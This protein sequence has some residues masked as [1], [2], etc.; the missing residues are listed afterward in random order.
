MGKALLEVWP[1][2]T[3]IAGAAFA[4]LG[5][6]GV[7][8]WRVSRWTAEHDSRVAQIRT[9]S[10]KLETRVDKLETRV[11]AVELTAASHTTRFE[12]LP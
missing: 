3:A 9:D 10:N 8:V 4:I 5:W 6:I 1:I 12:A 11:A 7:G 2:L